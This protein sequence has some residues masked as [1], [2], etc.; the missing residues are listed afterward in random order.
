MAHDTGFLF[1]ALNKETKKF[2]D[3]DWERARSLTKTLRV[4]NCAPLAYKSN[5]CS[6]SETISELPEPPCFCINKQWR[7]VAPM[8]RDH[9]NYAENDFATPRLFNSGSISFRC[10]SWQFIQGRFAKY[11]EVVI[12]P[13]EIRIKVQNLA[14]NYLFV[15]N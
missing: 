1:C 13:N 12:F 14:E 7:F 9:V 2:D 3:T 10:K 11:P 15:Y 5:Y 6:D 4:N 8:L